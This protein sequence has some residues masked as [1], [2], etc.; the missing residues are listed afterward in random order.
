MSTTLPTLL[1][2]RLL[3]IAFV[4]SIFVYNVILAKS[5]EIIINPNVKLLKDS[6]ENKNI[7][8]AINKFLETSQQKNEENKYI[9][10]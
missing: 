7:L 8:I 10:I 4:F 5:S 6:I 1:Q 2:I 9:Y 3:I